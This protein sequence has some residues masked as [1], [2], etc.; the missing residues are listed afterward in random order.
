MRKEA[1]ARGIGDGARAEFEEGAVGVIEDELQPRGGQRGDLVDPDGAGGPWDLGRAE[2]SWGIGTAVQLHDGVY[3][4]AAVGPLGL[5][6]DP[7]AGRGHLNEEPDGR[8][9]LRLHGKGRSPSRQGIGVPPPAHPYRRRHPKSAVPYCTVLVFE[10]G[11][12]ELNH[13][14]L[15]VRT[16]GAEEGSGQVPAFIGREFG[17]GYRLDGRGTGAG[18]SRAGRPQ[19]LVELVQLGGPPPSSSSTQA[20]RPAP[21]V[22]PQPLQDGKDCL[23]PPLLGARTCVYADVVGVLGLGG[24][25]RRSRGRVFSLA[26]RCGR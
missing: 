26:F 3:A 13:A 16:T 24:R 6:G 25:G 14:E 7:W 5:P 18:A 20:L 9:G 8:A 21:L 12:Q 11:G 15:G 1:L 23:L 17:G 22:A 19:Q 10:K 4:P 2:G